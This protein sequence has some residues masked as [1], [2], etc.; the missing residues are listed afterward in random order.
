MDDLTQE[1]LRKLSELDGWTNLSQADEAIKTY[2][3]LPEEMRDKLEA[4]SE[5]ARFLWTACVTACCFVPVASTCIRRPPF[6]GWCAA[7]A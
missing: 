7:P 6:S 1:N 2:L 3:S 4:L 5:F